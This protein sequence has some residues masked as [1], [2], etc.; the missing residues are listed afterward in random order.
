MNGE[1]EI[2]QEEVRRCEEVK[3]EEGSWHLGHNAR[4][5][6]SWWRNGSTVAARLFTMVWRVGRV[7]GDW[8]KAVIIPVHKEDSRMECT[9]YRG[10]SLMSIVGKCLKEFE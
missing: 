7:P 9:N 4:D 10:I 3:G 2:L 5:F 8:K 6:E 1:P